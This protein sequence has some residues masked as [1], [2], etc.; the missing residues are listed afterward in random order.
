M[1]TSKLH[2]CKGDP[3]VL[4]SEDGRFQCVITG[5]PLTPFLTKRGWLVQARKFKDGKTVYVNRSCHLLLAST[6]CACEDKHSFVR[7]KDGNRENYSVSNL[8]WVPKPRRPVAKRHP[9][10][11]TDEIIEDVYVRHRDWYVKLTTKMGLLY[12]DAEDVVQNAF[13]LMMT[14]RHRYN[15]E[16]MGP[17]TFLKYMWKLAMRT[18]GEVKVRREK[19]DVPEAVLYAADA[20]YDESEHSTE[21]LDPYELAGGSCPG[22]EEILTE[23]AEFEEIEQQYGEQTANVFLLLNSGFSPS[24]VAEIMGTT[25]ERIQSEIKRVQGV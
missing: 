4:V 16:V 5:R 22:P 11:L 15:P 6:F 13:L 7:F 12:E 18:H 8:E 25:T 17:V 24:D 1:S 14:V 19:I 20:M 2:L 21:R 23:N 9:L 3:N 10:V